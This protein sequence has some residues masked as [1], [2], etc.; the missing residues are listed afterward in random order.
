MLYGIVGTRKC[1]IE[2]LN[3]CYK[4][5]KNLLNYDKNK[6]EVPVLIRLSLIEVECTVDL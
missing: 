6:K 4:D 5:S 3:H 1:C 2:E